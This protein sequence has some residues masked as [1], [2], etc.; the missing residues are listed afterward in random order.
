METRSDPYPANLSVDYPELPR[1]RVT[2]LFRLILAVPILILW[3]VLT[4]QGLGI[5]DVNAGDSA[6]FSV[7]AGGVVFLATVLMLVFRHKYPGWWFHWN[8]NFLRFENRVLAYLLLLRDEYPA[9]DEEQAVQVLLPDPG[10][11]SQLNRWLPL[12]KWFLVIPHLVVL[13]VLALVTI[14]L[15]VIA[16]VV[17]LVT[18]RYPRGIYDF[19]VGTLRWGLRVEAYAFVLVTDRYPPFRL[20]A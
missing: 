14:V 13:I 10:D 3:S 18:G 12:I 19:V 17:I 6:R 20:A 2:T 1:N 15:T 8:L 7:H 16:W 11:A 5:I 9:T 4:D